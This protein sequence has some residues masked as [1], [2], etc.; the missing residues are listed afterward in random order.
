MYRRPYNGK[1]AARKDHPLCRQCFQSE[2]D[3]ERAKKLASNDN[4]TDELRA[5]AAPGG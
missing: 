4:V 2:C 3:R 5:W 1:L